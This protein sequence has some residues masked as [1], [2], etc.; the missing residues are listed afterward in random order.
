MRHTPHNG[1][2]R[3]VRRSHGRPRASTLKLSI[4]MPAYNEAATLAHAV[5]AVLSTPYPCEVELVIVDDGSTDATPEILGEVADPRVV[6]YRHPRNMGKGA[7]LQTAA[8]I[9]RGTHMVPFDA[10]LE[11]SPAD[12]P[13]LLE[14]VL[15]GRC[16]VVYGTRLFGVNTRYQSYRHGVG[17]RALTFAANLMFDAY[18]SDLHTCLKLMPLELFRSFDLRENG[19]GL[20]TEITA[21]ILKSG[22]RPF[23]VPVS[24]HSRSYDEGKKITSV[25]GVECLHV[26][27][28]VRFGSVRGR[29]RRAL[30][31]GRAGGEVHATRPEPVVEVLDNEPARE[32]A[33]SL[34]ARDGAAA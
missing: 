22:I 17:N 33:N 14:P 8:A 12:L 3:F 7:A 32:F 20:D 4:L 1:K 34:K 16:E 30:R 10:D 28:R 31:G 24:Y 19:F 5:D 23:E 26:L 13:R 2:T 21:R 15:E 25:H 11:Y 29:A 6:V 9:A 18:L 27:A